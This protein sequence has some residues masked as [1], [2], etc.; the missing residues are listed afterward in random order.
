M[1]QDRIL[2]G[3]RIVIVV[4]HFNGGDNNSCYLVCFCNNNCDYI[5]FRVS[6]GHWVIQIIDRCHCF[7]RGKHCSLVVLLCYI[8]L[9]Q[10]QPQQTLQKS[11][12]TNKSKSPQCGPGLMTTFKLPLLLFFVC[13]VFLFLLD[14]TVRMSML[15]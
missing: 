9:M 3:T 6:N 13:F 4:L 1:R 2:V 8:P 10:L 11:T 12:S 7:C 15:G 5:F 14:T